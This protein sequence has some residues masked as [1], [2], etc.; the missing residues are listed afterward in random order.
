MDYL[1]KRK[2]SCKNKV[3][4]RILRLFTGIF[5]VLLFSGIAHAQIQQKPDVEV[6]KKPTRKK[7]RLKVSQTFQ[8]SD[9]IPEGSGLC[10]WKG[11]LWTHNDSGEPVLFSLDTATGKIIE[12][13][14]LPGVANNDWEDLAQDEDY[15]YLG[16]TGN[17]TEKKDTVEILRIGKHDLIRQKPSIEKIRFTWPETLTDGKRKKINFNCEAITVVGDS[18]YLFTKEQKRGRR[19]RIFTLSNRPGLSVAKYKSTLKTRILITGVSYD[20]GTK[21]LVLC[22]YNLLLRPFLLVFPETENHDFFGGN[23]KQIKLRIPFHQVEGVATSDGKR[24]YAINEKWHLYFF[25]TRQKL[26]VIELE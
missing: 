26:H 23:M 25:H 7:S 13:Y 21:Q 20:S 4:H 6:F 8:L 18:L 22:G 19:T 10:V 17:N 15:F 3:K 2:D 12:K 14:L 16:A 1:I 9:E 11:M 24:Y 5:L